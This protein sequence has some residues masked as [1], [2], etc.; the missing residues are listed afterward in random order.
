MMYVPV[1]KLYEKNMKNIIFSHI[2]EV[3]VEMSRIRSWIPI[4]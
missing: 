4:H 2:L 1:G 3:I